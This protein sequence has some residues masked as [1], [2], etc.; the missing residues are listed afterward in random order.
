MQD[1]TPE[2]LPG[3]V[4]DDLLAM[5]G[6]PGTSHLE[7]SIRAGCVQLVASALIEVQLATPSYSISDGAGNYPEVGIPFCSF[8]CPLKVAN[9]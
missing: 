3:G 2:R 8:T 4:R 7:A 9:T 5:L 1:A 6:N